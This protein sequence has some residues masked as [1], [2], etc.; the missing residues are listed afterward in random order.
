M[1]YQL[2]FILLTILSTM[3]SCLP[4]QHKRQPMDGTKPVWYSLKPFDHMD[5]YT[6]IGL[7]GSPGWRWDGSREFPRL[8][9][10]SHQRDEAG[11]CKSLPDFMRDKTI[12]YEVQNGCCTFYSGN[13]C[14]HRLW[15]GKNKKEWAVD[16]KLQKKACSYKCNYKDCH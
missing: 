16:N 7:Y 2:T 11:R 9:I 5:G 15:T 3:S 4:T 13:H 14:Q 8:Q 12:S 6:Q 10:Y 1:N